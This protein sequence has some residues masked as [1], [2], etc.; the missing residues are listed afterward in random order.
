MKGR[1]K[2]KGREGLAEWWGAAGF[3]LAELLAVIA[4]MAILLALSV[5]AFRAFGQGRALEAAVT[6][7]KTALSLARQHAVTY[8]RYTYVVFPTREDVVSPE[9]Y[10]KA[11]RS[12]AVFTVTNRATGSGRYLSSWMFLPEGIVFDTNAYKDTAV[13]NASYT[14]RV[15]FPT[16]SSPLR[17][18]H[19]LGFKP[20]GSVTRGDGGH[21]Y[22]RE[23]WVV[24]TSNSL[25][26]GVKPTRVGREIYVYGLTG[27][28]R[29][30]D[31]PP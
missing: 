8:R 21:L 31:F 20:D 27:G 15:P 28:V 11:Y 4:I 17:N 29:V 9:D 5:P 18:L 23:G 19:C 30:Q 10:F 1:R 6:Q 24:A 3:T 16:E 26:Y 25:D 7:L 2:R 14:N 13:F 12:Y 22:V